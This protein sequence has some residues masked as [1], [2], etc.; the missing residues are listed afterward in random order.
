[1][2]LTLLFS[3]VLTALLIETNELKAQQEGMAY[4]WNLGGNFSRLNG[5]SEPVNSKTG[6]GYHVGFILSQRW[7]KSAFD[8]ELYYNRANTRVDEFDVD[9]KM[10]QLGIE[11]RYRFFPFKKANIQIGYLWSFDVNWNNTETLERFNYGLVAGLGYD[12]NERF[13]LDLNFFQSAKPI[14]RIQWEEKYL[15][16]QGNSRVRYVTDYFYLATIS[17]NLRYYL[18]IDHPDDFPND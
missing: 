2:K 6:M 17:L 16:D 1:M 8:G 9:L 10:K 14:T 18:G 5:Q 13:G 4:G 15:D 7:N 12:F 11:L 3:L